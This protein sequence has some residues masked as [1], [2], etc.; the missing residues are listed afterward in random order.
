MAADTTLARVM[1]RDG[2]DRDARLSEAHTWLK[3]RFE[4]LAPRLRH[5]P[6]W[7]GLAEDMA[8]DGIK[9]GK[10]TP[11]T[12]RAVRE[13]WS[14][15][16][17]AVEAEETVRTRAARTSPRQG[18]A[19]QNLRLREQERSVDANQPPPVV[20]APAPRL[21]VPSYPPPASRPVT[22]HLPHAADPRPHEEL[23]EEEREAYAEAQILRLR[24]KVAEMSGHDPDEIR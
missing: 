21:P 3:R 12:S 13:I 7:R 24:R 23:S 19:A 14:R 8:A 11:L 15:V 1:A 2:R 20:T 17:E 16:C 6:G 4:T 9:G 10:G 5:N 18:E 22:P